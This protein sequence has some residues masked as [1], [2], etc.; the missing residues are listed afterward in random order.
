MKKIVGLWVLYLSASVCG[1]SQVDSSF[2]YNTNMPYGTLDLR[3]AKSPTRYYYLQEDTTFSFRESSPGVKTHTYT[4][5][6]TWNTSAYGEGN[7]R[8]KNGSIDNFI[9]NYR[10]LKPQNYNA[11]YSPGYPIMIMF[12]GGGEAANCWIDE[13]CNWATADYNPI[14]NSPPAPTDPDHKLLNNDRN[15]LHGGTIHLTAVNAAGSK[16]PNDPKLSSRAF[17]GFVLFPQSL[18]GWGPHGKAEDAIRILRLIIKKYNIDESRVYIQGLSNGGGG[19]YQAL[20][21]APWLFAAALPMSAVN[22]AGIVNDGMTPEVSKLPLWVFQGGQDINPTPGRTYNTVRSFRDAGAVVRY[23]LYPN[24]GHGTWNMA[25]KE[26]DFFTWI[27]KHRKYN[28]HVFYGNPIICNTTQAGARMGFSKGYFAYEWQRDGQT[29]AGEN[30][31]E[32]ITNIPGTYRGRFSRKPNPAEG[33]WERWSDPIVVSEMNPVKPSIQIIGTAHLRGPGLLSTVENNTVKLRAEQPAELYNWFKNGEP[34]NFPGTDVEDTLR[35][36]PFTSGNSEG[37]GTYT[38]VTKNSYCPSPPS[39]PVNLFF[40]ESSPKNLVLSSDRIGFKGTVT[41]S[42]IFLSWNDVS[43]LENGYEIWRRK[44]GAPD[45][46]W[47]TKTMEDGIS[48]QDINLD[49][50]TTYEYKLRAVNNTGHSN[51]V[52]SDEL[53]I[54]YQFTTAG[55]FKFPPPPQDLSVV[56][57]TLTTVTLSWKPAK[58]ESGV[59]E[60]YIYFN[61]D[62]INTGSQ[63]TTYTLTGLVM[64]T[65]YAVYVKAVDFGNHFSQPSNQVI[66]TTYLSGLTYKHSTGAWLDLDDSAM[67]ATWV[68]PEFTGAVPNFTLQPRTQDDFFNFQFSGYL[69]ILTE[70]NYYFNITSNDGSRLLLNGVILADND[71]IHAARTITSEPI[72]LTVGPHPIEVQYF[73]DVG[74]HTLTVRY[75]GP[76]IGDGS[77]FVAIPDVAL[78]SGTYIPPPPPASPSDLIASSVG[79]ER[80]DITWQFTDDEYTDYEIYRASSALGPFNIVARAKGITAI[81]SIGLVPNT[82]YYYKVRSVSNNGTSVFTSVVSASTMPDNVAP[83]VPVDLQIIGKTLTDLAISWKPATDNVRV[84]GYEIFSG[85]ELIGTSTIHAFT[86]KGLSLDTQYLFSVKALDASGNRSEASVQ[87]AIVTTSTTV[88]YSLSTGNL[89]D[90]ATWRRN[91]DGSGESPL[92]FS[93]NGQYFM[94]TNRTTSSIG[95]SWTVGGAS[96]RV[97]VPAGVTLTADQ[98]FSANV[99]LQGSASLNLNHEMAPNLLKLSP[100]STVNF[101]VYPSVTKNTYGNIILSGTVSKNFAPDTITVLGNLTIHEGL[102]L[103]GSPHNSTHIRLGGTLT[104][105][106]ARPATAADNGV[107]IAF[108]GGTAQSIITDSDVYLYR[109]ITSAN[110][111]L[112]VVSPLGIPIKVYAGSLN[113]GGLLLNNES[114]LNLSANDLI[115][116]DSAVINSDQQTGKI[117]INGGDIRITSASSQNSYL[118]FDPV[119]HLIDSLGINLSG[120]GSVSVLS[121]LNISDGIKVVNGTLFSGGNITLVSN[122]AK[123]AVIYEIENAGVITGEVS[124][125][126]QLEPSGNVFH[127]LSTPVSGVTVASWQSSFPVTGQFTGASTGNGLTASPS[128]FTYQGST[129]G[130]VAYPPAGGS[131]TAPIERGRGYAAFLHNGTDPITLQV[132]GNPFQGNITFPLLAGSTGVARQGWNLIGNPYASPILW[133]NNEAAWNRSGINNIVAIRKNKSVNG[134]IRSQVVYYDLLLGGGIIPEGEAFWVRTFSTSP[135]LSIKE[136]AKLSVDKPDD[137]KSSV[138]YLVINLNQ[139]EISDPAY[140]LF[141]DLGTDGFD[142]QYDGKKMNNY[143]MFNFSSIVGDTVSLAVN[144]LTNAFCTKTVKLNLTDVSPGS[145]SFSFQNMQ[146]LSSIGDLVLIDHYM[147]VSTT[148]NGSPYNFTITEDAQSFGS[149]RFA[150]IFT[151]NSVDVTTPK[152]SA[153][154]ICAP[155]KGYVSITNSQIGVSYQVINVNGKIISSPAEGN[156]GK[157]ELE[158]FSGELIS[159]ANQIK[160]S[161]GFSGCER[162]I[163]PSEI[164]VNYISELTVQTTGDISIC[165]GSD[166][167][168]EASGAPAGGF[169]KWFDSDGVLIEGATLSSFLV[170][171]VFT[172]KV[173]YVASANTIGCES[174]RAEIHIYKDTLATP[175]IQV[176]NDTLMTNVVA[177]YQWKK[178]GTPITGA[179]LHYFKPIDNGSYSVVVSNGDCFKESSPFKFATADP[180][181]G[182]DPGDEDQPDPVTGIENVHNNEFLLHIY[183][184]PSSGLALNVI[185]RS[186]K[187]DPVQIEIIDMMGRIHLS[188]WYDVNALATGISIVPFA[189][190][191]NGI[192]FVKA[193]QLDIK[194]MKKIIIKD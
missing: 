194:I 127:Y 130:W 57:N 101:N 151:K 18:N 134:Q 122:A 15:L 117:S 177:H 153:N 46:V 158:I 98:P 192:Y 149:S 71:G 19:V 126:Q 167:T 80:I 31:A 87:L 166:V 142:E 70:D 37:N 32:L 14:T 155:G 60:Y 77:T 74:G 1:F 173:Y 104:L 76:G 124:V 110:Q 154:D 89:N 43:G 52:P 50:G 27:L 109:L 53:G 120:S 25:Y 38:L 16:L 171:N 59:K 79:M 145:Y 67:V 8:E 7:L 103:K 141:T 5:M 83:T 95:G 156:G 178:D 94:V 36:A 84:T 99:E 112:N 92:N 44:A 157:I 105:F 113:G 163:L 180:G 9:M 133:N 3:L 28:P 106:G 2:I 66:A 187:T 116:G 174:K 132:K 135:A 58:D 131:N 129:E 30:G 41:A 143:G 159:G 75:S 13:R 136:K 72:Y 193:T 183:P 161:A 11:S 189:P 148:L 49:P 69:N 160:V 34:V 91:L 191:N 54:N 29:I 147:G 107:D 162:L 96:S 121:P 81:D 6:T 165:E 138:N 42:S 119:H 169:Y 152:I 108:T 4:K 35:L 73:D 55:D 170:S 82:L 68:N 164:V 168:L 45:F 184:V 188:K 115:L 22:D 175:I 102:A 190:L 64:N 150:F 144:N 118:Y 39:D 140:L 12:H 139:G 40:N 172:E 24:L 17:P 90:L 51:Y 33:D 48:Y 146:S 182:E 176:K 65:A 114:V 10:L 185:V 181:D 26:P 137:G 123:T 97:I 63:S 125:Q 186:P 47:V 23:Y 100:L 78:R 85:D 111:T 21:R 179:T 88:F 62:S 128:L 93:D 86:A 56:S 61:K 20:K